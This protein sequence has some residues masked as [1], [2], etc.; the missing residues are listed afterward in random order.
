MKVETININNAEM[1]KWLIEE[2]SAELKSQLTVS[3]QVCNI[4]E[5]QMRVAEKRAKQSEPK[6]R[7]ASSTSLK[8]PF[9]PHRNRSVKHIPCQ[10]AILAQ[11]NQLTTFADN[12]IRQEF[13]IGE[14][15]FGVVRASHIVFMDLFRTTVFTTLIHTSILSFS[16]H[17]DIVYSKNSGPMI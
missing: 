1:Q 7:F 4:I 15:R 2:E 11:P 5:K 14:G 12:S 8:R 16:I 3:K 17:L 10:D 13:N 6:S 9:P